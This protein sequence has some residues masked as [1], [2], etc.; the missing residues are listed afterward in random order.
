MSAANQS[1]LPSLECRPIRP[2]DIAY[3]VVANNDRA[4]IHVDPAAAAAAGLP[5]CVAPGSFVLGHI[6][7]LLERFAGPGRVRQ[8]Q[9]RFRA[10]VYAG[11]TLTAGGAI[12]KQSGEQ[13]MLDVWVKRADKTLV[14]T[15]EAVV[16]TP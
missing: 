16:R 14:A 9:V 11:D 10:A 8:L 12:T 1:E 5:G 4:D 3:M 2:I 15:G 7:V 13:T 6:G